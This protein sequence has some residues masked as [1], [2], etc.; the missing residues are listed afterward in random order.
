LKTRI[1]HSAKSGELGVAF[2]GGGKMQ[3]RLIGGGTIG[4]FPN[5]DFLVRGGNLGGK[6]GTGLATQHNADKGEEGK[7]CDSP[8]QPP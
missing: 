8:D 2:M 4:N 1:P 6:W 7:V 5:L 3:S